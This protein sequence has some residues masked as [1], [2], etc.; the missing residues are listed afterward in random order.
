MKATKKK[1][2]R[3][4]LEGLME[5]SAAHIGIRAEDLRSIAKKGEMKTYDAGTWLFH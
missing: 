5:A 1:T 4:P 3:K 2:P